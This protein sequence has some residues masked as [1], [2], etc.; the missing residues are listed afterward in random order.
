M[1]KSSVF[2]NHTLLNEVISSFHLDLN[3][4]HG[5][6]HWERVYIN[7]LKLSKYYQVNSEV[8]ELFSLLHDS[9]RKTEYED[10]E[11]GKRSGLFIKELINNRIIQ[12]SNEDKKRLI[13]ACSNHTKPNKN[14]KLYL[15]PV[16]QICFDADRLDIGRVGIIPEEKYFLTKYAKRLVEDEKY[17]YP[18]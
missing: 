5:I 4:D 1:Y 11:H 6:L 13:F 10:I 8:F 9:K 17:Y 3:G 16:V 2:K 18:F 7:C 15:D 12:L 14:A